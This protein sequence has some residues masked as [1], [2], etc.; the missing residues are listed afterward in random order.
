M[1]ANSAE[2]PHSD[3]V[4]AAGDARG[5]SHYMGVGDMDGD[6]WMEIA[7]GAKV[8]HLRMAIG[9]LSG[10]IRGKKKQRLHG[11]KQCLLKISS[12]QPTFSQQMSMGMGKPIGWH[13]EAMELA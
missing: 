12:A 7:V 1:S 11:K 3:G 8:H 10:K 9:L 13:Q 4:F 5:G 2:H 6:G